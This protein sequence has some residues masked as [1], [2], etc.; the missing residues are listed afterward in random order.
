EEYSKFLFEKL[1]FS[2]SIIKNKITNLF[3]NFKNNSLNKESL[4]NKI[5]SRNNILIDCNL[6]KNNYDK[7]IIA[8]LSSRDAT[9]IVFEKFPDQIQNKLFKIHYQFMNKIK[10]ILDFYENDNSKLSIIEKQSDFLNFVRE[11]Y[12]EI[13]DDNYYD[14]FIFC[15]NK[16]NSVINNFDYN[17]DNLIKL[18]NNCYKHELIS[19]N[20]ILKNLISK[21]KINCNND[22]IK[23]FMK[24]IDEN[25][26][27]IKNLQNN[28]N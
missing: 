22:Q 11:K 2:Q 4:E 23:S 20:G 19:R 14:D 18:I 28:K 12:S 21:D 15:F 13:L 24:V 8:C 17:Y 1:S 25:N 7:I 16:S 3:N 10:L 6:V 5:F 26:L 9:R 27:K